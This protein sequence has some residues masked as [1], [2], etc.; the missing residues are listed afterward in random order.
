MTISLIDHWPSFDGGIEIP[1]HRLAAYQL[2]GNP[3]HGRDA[4]ERQ[5]IVAR[6]LPGTW[7]SAAPGQ[8]RIYCHRLAEPYIREALR[9]CEA[10]GVLDELE[11]L[12]C[13]NRRRIR[14]SKR[15][16]WSFHAMGVAVD[17]NPHQN[18]AKGDLGDI[19]P[20]SPAW[21]KHWPDG[22]SQ[23]FVTCWESVGW[24]WGGRWR[25]F[26]DPM[27]VQLVGRERR[28]ATR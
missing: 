13:Y 27:H 8:G 7:N 10:A 5:C 12:G 23:R 19:E 26:R 3:N 22:L 11:R 18:R 2:Y 9:R 15:G 24:R 21:Q 4:I 25:H 17:P 14:H 20:F 28:P 6:K 1:Q 16:P